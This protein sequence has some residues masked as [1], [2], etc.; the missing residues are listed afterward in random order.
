MCGRNA[1]QRE[2]DLAAVRWC[3]CTKTQ[4]Q[5]I[6]S[7]PNSHGFVPTTTTFSK[8]QK[9]GVLCN[10]VQKTCIKNARTVREL[11]CAM[12]R[13]LYVCRQSHINRRPTPAT[14]K[15]RGR[16]PCLCEEKRESKVTLLKILNPFIYTH[17]HGGATRRFTAALCIYIGSPCLTPLSRKA[18]HSLSQLWPALLPTILPHPQK[19]PPRSSPWLMVRQR[20]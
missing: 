14:L 2:F 1:K 15:R 8:T 16:S 3:H 5:L 18:P 10:S 6:G 13:L 11:M 12:S 17:M 20:Q 7:A 19:H 4:K 9:I